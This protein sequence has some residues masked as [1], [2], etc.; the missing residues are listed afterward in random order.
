M[1]AGVGCLV[2]AAWVCA[3]PAF[4]Q[5]AMAT[6]STV[7]QLKQL[8]LEELLALQV[9]VVSR[10][11]EAAGRAAAAVEVIT[12]EQIERTGAA[13]VP[14]ALRLATGVQVSRFAGHSFA[15]SSRGF[16]SLAANKLQV[17]QDGRSLYSPLFS[18][19]FWDAYGVMLE[20]VDRIEVV[21]GPAAI[22][23]GANAVNGVINIVSKRALDTQGTLVTA[24][25]GTEE[26]AFA[27]VRHGGRLGPRSHYRVYVRYHDR[28]PMALS[29]G[30]DAPGSPWETQAGFRIDGESSQQD[31]FTLQGDYSYNEADVPG[32]AQPF[33]RQAYLLGRWA[34]SVGADAE[35]QIQTY[36]DRFERNVPGQFGEERNTFDLDTQYAGRLGSRQHWVVG[37]AGRVSK[38]DTRAGG[39]TQ[40]MPRGKTVELFSAFLL[41]EI[42]LVPDRLVAV[43]GSRLEWSSLAGREPQ[44]SLRLAWTPTDR[45]MLWGALSRSVRM[46]S[47]IDEDLRF[48]PVPAN[49]V[50]LVSGNPG[51]E[52]ERAEA[53]EVGY[54]VQMAD[55]VS[56]DVAGFWQDFDNL[57]SL[58]PSPPLGIPLLQRNRLEAETSGVEVAVKVQVSPRW[59]LNGSYTHLRQVLRP[60]ADSRDPNR[61]TLEGN[62]APDIYS[63]WSSWELPRSVTLDGVLR[64]VAALPSP[65]VPAY[66][67]LDVRL[68]W[69]PTHSLQLAVVGQNLLHARHR[70]YG[71]GTPAASEVQRGGYAKATWRF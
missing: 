31:R 15:V 7:Q 42:T 8:S 28:S 37:L 55:R 41:D 5:P 61:G 27:A 26:R 33:N 35:F 63:L 43:L 16:T 60:R 44:P 11:P 30:A 66:T 69:W 62:D 23:W 34:R 20:D 1:A 54:R 12:H 49:G 57:R 38:D 48:I 19:V 25:G 67:E 46:P 45:Q 65:A 4:A 71:A 36:F 56:L 3:S 6:R 59:R 21:R 17:M 9:T 52:P 64:R 53:V 22:M 18:G 68:G 10:H 32:P 39:T 51:F 40:F 13:S 29:S 58:E 14:D 70:E 47:R 2:I 24:G 50:V